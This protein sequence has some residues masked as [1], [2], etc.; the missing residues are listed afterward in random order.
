MGGFGTTLNS[1]DCEAVRAAKIRRNSAEKT[2]CARRT[3][4]IYFR[5][6][7]SH[8]P[9][10]EKT[11]FRI[12]TF[13]D[14]FWSV[15]L[16]III[17]TCHMEEGPIHSTT[18]GGGRDSAASIQFL[19]TVIIIIIIF[20]VTFFTRIWVSISVCYIVCRVY[21]L[22]YGPFSELVLLLLLLLL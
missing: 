14:F 19:F 8:P 20:I 2:G 16:I 3:H 13:Y 10:I 12:M 4:W 15:I 7:G 9:T 1:G 5:P 18:I 6:K 21:M 22:C 11:P 17:I